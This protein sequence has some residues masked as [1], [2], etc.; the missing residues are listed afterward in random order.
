LDSLTKLG[1]PG[2]DTGPFSGCPICAYGPADEENVAQGLPPYPR[3]CACDA[4]VKANHFK[5]C[6]TAT[7]H[8]AANNKNFFNEA[9][10]EIRQLEVDGKL[11]LACFVDLAN[12]GDNNCD[13]DLHCAREDAQASTG[14]IDING[15]VGFVCSHSCPLTGMFV[16]MKTPEQ[17]IYYLVLL[18]HLVKLCVQSSVHLRDVYVDFAC[19][20]FKTWM[21]FVDKQ[22]SMFKEGSETMMARDLRILVNWM[23]GSSHTLACQLLNN[24]RY[25]VDAGRKVGENSEQLWSMTKVSDMQLIT[26]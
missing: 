17:F 16:D 20:L 8:I 15:I 12:T 22:A 1:V 2:M 26:L 18:K 19:R 3:A 14:T 24:G 11:S 5:K 9:E 6:G 21:R 13:N 23:H 4:V 25:I 7:K 10:E